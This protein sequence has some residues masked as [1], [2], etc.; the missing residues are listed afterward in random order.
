MTSSE[1]RPGRKPVCKSL[2]LALLGSALVLLTSGAASAADAG[3]C[4]ALSKAGLFDHT[5]IA[6][7]KL[8]AA[9]AAGKLPAY[10]E[11]TG[12]ISPVPGS[13]I[14]VVYRLPEHWNGKMVGL[15]GGGFAGNIT[16]NR[17]DAGSYINSAAG[18]L[19]EGYAVAQTDAGHPSANAGDTS[20]ILKAKGEFN[21]P[22]IIDFG[23]RAVHEMT[24][25]GKQVIANYYGR[26][27]DKA[28]FIGCS[29]GGRMGLE[30][31][32]RYPA[33]YDGVVAGAPVSNYQV[34]TN[35][36]LRTQF[37]HKEKG[38]NLTADQVRAVHEAVLKACDANDGLKDDIITDPRTCKWDPAELEC[39]TTA[40]KTCLTAQQ[41]ATVRNDYAGVT[42]ADGTVA[43]DPF[44]RG[45]E[46]NWL[47]RSIGNARMPMGSDALIGAG[48]LSY[49]L[50]EDPHYDLMSFD[51]KTDISKIENSEGAK[52]LLM[53][54]PDISPFLKH[55][56]KLLLW[57]GFNDPGP[58][59][60]E[61]IKYYEAVTHAMAPEFGGMTS[62]AKDVRM[63]LAPGV[64]HCGDGPGPTEFNMA[65]AIDN[66][67][68]SG[69]P[70]STIIVSKEG[71]PIKR[72]LCPYPALPY[73]NGHGDANDPA[74]F[75]CKV[76]PPNATAA[77][78]ASVQ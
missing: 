36:T 70:P 52:I 71:A 2:R 74:N 68:E 11:V 24:T 23:Y 66:W 49:I 47:S 54:N 63:F 67:V 72:P 3:S 5:T 25:V 37:F 73:Y 78:H 1:I 40:A 76:L 33:D 58:S 35:A 6:S 75:T 22:Q 45:G 48:V 7:A 42:L 10:C 56:G 21:Q 4:S 53:T 20:W 18:K 46:L 31:V 9:N 39:G 55:G 64:Y 51:P 38:S 65:G 30:E 69:T 41:V 32:T 17:F 8:I 77:E 15:G 29:T 34:Y 26:A 60:L 43:A 61:T 57:Q 62:I 44:M 28:Y 19:R 59:P 13:H 12:T 27:E 14:G 50:F 16:L